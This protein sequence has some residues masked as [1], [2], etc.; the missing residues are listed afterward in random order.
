VL[1]VT[2]AGLLTAPPAAA[3]LSCFATLSYVAFTLQYFCEPSAVEPA[4][5]LDVAAY[6]A[7]R[8]STRIAAPQVAQQQGKYLAKMIKN[9]VKPG[10]QVPEGVK[11]FR[12]SHKGSLAYVGNDKAVMDVPT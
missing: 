6:D 8:S 5:T 2:A 9:G 11:P 7:R 4:R 1:L 10:M 3:E 12:Y